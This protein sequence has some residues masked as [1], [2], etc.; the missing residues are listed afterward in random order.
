MSPMPRTDQGPALRDA[1][2]SLKRLRHQERNWDKREERER[3][4]EGQEGMGKEEGG[5]RK[6]KGR[7]AHRR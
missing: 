1:A 7:D 5:G 2:R 4:L 3:R 6:G